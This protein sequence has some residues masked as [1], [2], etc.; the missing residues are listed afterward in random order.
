MIAYV[1]GQDGQNL[2]GAITT[3]SGRDFVDDPSACEAF[4]W[5]RFSDGALV[6]VHQGN[7]PTGS[8]FINDACDFNGGCTEKCEFIQEPTRVNII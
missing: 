5:C 7:C 1:Y 8:V 3:P 2:C 4:L 6:D